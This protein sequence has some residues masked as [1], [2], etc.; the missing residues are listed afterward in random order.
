MIGVVGHRDLRAEDEPALE[1]AVAQVLQWLQRTHPHTPLLLVT[2]LAEGADQLVARVGLAQ[3]CAL[4]VALPCAQ[5][6]HERDFTTPAARE[7]FRALLPRARAVTVVPAPDGIVAQSPYERLA[8]YQARQAQVLLALWNGQHNGASGG[9]AETVTFALEGIPARLDPQRHPLAPRET[10]PVIHI[11]TP[12]RSGPPARPSTFDP[13]RYP[14]LVRTLED[15][16]PPAPAT[17]VLRR[18]LLLLSRLEQFNRDAARIARAGATASALLPEAARAAAEPLLTL[19]ARAD[20]L[21]VRLHDRW[22]VSLR[23][24][25]VMAGTAVL[26]LMAFGVR[27]EQRLFLAAYFLALALSLTL[28]LWGRARAYERRFLDYRCLAE[29][30]RVQIFWRLAGVPLEVEQAYLRKQSGELDWIRQALRAGG[31]LRPPGP[32]VPGALRL[33]LDGWLADQVRYFGRPGHEGRAAARHRLRATLQRTAWSMY[34][35]TLLLACVVWAGWGSDLLVVLMALGPAS[36]SLIQMYLDR[37]CLSDEA[38][39]YAQ[40]GLVFGLAEQRL[41]ALLEH[42][43]PDPAREAEAMNLLVELG[44]DALVENGDWLLLH[45]KKPVEFIPV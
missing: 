6:E 35:L 9:T 15:R 27:P 1:R 18:R 30:L 10:G 17:D 2:S 40:A 13:Q 22:L 33:V 12:R 19:F 24:L 32:P 38:Q 41:R 4:Q 25:C 28:L 39:E 43:P 36:Y 3:G 7:A 37:S 14:I 42:E 31:L 21:A 23:V 16:R 34:G 5:A 20:G 8:A 45:R 26:S 44:R 29:G 11:V